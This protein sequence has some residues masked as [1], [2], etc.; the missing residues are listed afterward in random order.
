MSAQMQAALEQLNN[1]TKRGY[2][3]QEDGSQGAPKYCLSMPL[4]GS[5]PPATANEMVVRLVTL[6]IAA[7]GRQSLPQVGK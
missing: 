1:A 3:I 4:G 5:Y 7:D 2:T 6:K